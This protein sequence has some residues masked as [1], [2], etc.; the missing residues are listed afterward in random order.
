[1]NLPPQAAE[2]TARVRGWWG[3]APLVQRLTIV[4]VVVA[5]VAALGVAIYSSGKGKDNWE[6]AILYAD[7]DYQEAA[8]VSRKLTEM[9]VPH[10]LTEDASAILVPTDRARDLRLQLAGQGYP[11]TGRMGFEIFDEAKFAMTDFLQKVNF[12]RAL[13][14]ELEKTLEGLDQVRTARVHLVIPEPSLFTEEQKAVKAS[15]ELTL[16]S[17][18][19]L[20][21]ERVNAITYLVAASV[22][23][24]ELDNVTIVDTQGNLLTEE[25]DPLVRMANKQFEMQQQV[26]H[27]LEAK[28]QTL[29][30]QVI[31][32]D[33]SRVRVNVTLDFSQRNTESHT[34]DPGETQAIISEETTNKESAEQGT[35]EQAIRNYE[36]SRTIQNIVGSVGAVQRITM[37]L[38]IDKTKVVLGQT[39][40]FTEADRS[41][42]EI[43]KLAGLAREAVGFDPQRGDKVAVYAMTFDKTQEIK[44]HAD[45]Q[46][47][48]RKEFWTNIAINVAKIL[49]IIAALIT[50]RFIIQAIGR[51]VGVEEELEVLGVVGPDTREESFEREETPHEMVLGRVQQMVRDRPEDAAKLIKTMLTETS[52]A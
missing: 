14:A 40:E 2:M 33:R 50:L 17:N 31:G 4:G 11:R 1:M 39:G 51:G 32:K 35:E 9:Q 18:Q 23:G 10:R 25:K 52:R 8:D 45:A 34:V 46:A 22:E 38:T 16:A 19:R 42:E 24:L 36:V 47:A 7:L 13:Q 29:M 6:A 37:A 3:E 5:V 30:D 43:D 49:G 28:V 12:Q 15:V 21:P 26:E 20:K 48:E 44:A 41:Q 27:V